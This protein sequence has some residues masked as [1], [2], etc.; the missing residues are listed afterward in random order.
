MSNQI[1]NLAA[2][3]SAL[4]TPMPTATNS[5]AQTTNPIPNPEKNA[6][7][8]LQT[9]F[10][11]ENVKLEKATIEDKNAHSA[12]AQQVKYV[13]Q[14]S[15]ILSDAYKYVFY[16]YMALAVISCVVIFFKS[17]LS[18]MY[19][20]L[21][22]LV[23]LLFPFYIYPF[24]NIVYI[25]FIYT[26]DL[27][28]SNIYSNGFAS[29]Q[30]EYGGSDIRK[31]N[32]VKLVIPKLE[33]QLA[34]L[35]N[36]LPGFFNKLGSAAKKVGDQVESGGEKAVAGIKS[37]GEQAA[38]GIKKGGEQAITGLK[39]GTSKA[40]SALQPAFDSADEAFK[41]AWRK[42]QEAAIVAANASAKAL[43]IN[44]MPDL[45][46]A[47]EETAKVAN[48]LSDV[49]RAQANIAQ[50]EFNDV[51]DKMDAEAKYLAS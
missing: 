39:S 47:A 35:T 33:P 6:Y 31:L 2:A 12:D 38:A 13:N 29:T 9:Y 4:N 51:K 8:S 36:P 1:N 45:R 3:V 25:G 43:D 30:M 17:G 49:L 34:N 37:G 44:L 23:I 41:T 7:D 32:P 19:Q 16:I 14:S 50:K 40:V 48:S 5:P 21:L 46:K 42:S 27:V 28:L 18:W 10:K 26:Y 22:D 11:N 20:I 24:Q 15:K